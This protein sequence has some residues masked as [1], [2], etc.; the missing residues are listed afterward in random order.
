MP[1]PKG[2]TITLYEKTQSGADG[3]N[4]PVY[5]ETEI[6]VS[7][8]LVYPAGVSDELTDTLYLSAGRTVYNLGIPKGDTHVWAGNDVGFFGKR[9]KVIGEPVQGIEELI[10]LKWNRKVQVEAIE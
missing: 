6:S 4:R 10:P 3:F 5:T 9:W 1:K 7:N 8:V 2:I